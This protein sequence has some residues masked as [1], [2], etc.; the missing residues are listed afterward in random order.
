MLISSSD[1]CLEDALQQFTP[2]IVSRMFEHLR[3]DGIVARVRANC[4]NASNTNNAIL[5]F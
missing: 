2:T 5:S 1:A 3:A 4:E